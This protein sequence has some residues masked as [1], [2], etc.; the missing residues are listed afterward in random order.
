ILIA[1]AV[2]LASEDELT[3]NG[4]IAL[5]LCLYANVMTRH[6]ALV[7]FVVLPLAFLFGTIT[8]LPDQRKRRAHFRK[9]LITSAVGAAAFIAAKLTVLDLCLAFHEPYRSVTARSLTYPFDLIDRMPAEYKAA[10]P[11]LFADIRAAIVHSLS[12]TT[13]SDIIQFLYQNAKRSLA[14]YRSSSDLRKKTGHLASCSADADFQ[15]HRAE[16]RWWLR[17][18]D[19]IP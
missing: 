8:F 17:G 1:I 19:P 5:G 10:P 9:F 13:P 18:F 7:Y 16:E 3:R 6:N 12:R 11:A 4:L 2:H 14:L 15:I